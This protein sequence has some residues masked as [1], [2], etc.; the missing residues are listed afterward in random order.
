[1]TAVTIKLFLPFGEANRLRIAEVSNW[2]GMALA[3]PRTDLQ[4]LLERAE[5]DR[6]GIYMLAGVD[7][8]TGK[9]QVYV[10]EAECLR[11]RLRQHRGEDFWVQAYV[12]LSKD[13]NLTKGHVRYLEGRLIEEARAANRAAIVNAQSSGARLPESDRE[14]MEAFLG[15]VRQLLPVLGSD[16]L[17]PVLPAGTGTGA[18]G[19]LVHRIKGLTARG[20]RTAE[21][22]VVLAESQAVRAERP[23][24]AARHPFVVELRRKLLAEGALVSDGEYLRFTR[25][26]VFSSPS[27]AAAVLQGGGANGLTAWRTDGG[28]T[29]KALEA[30]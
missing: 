12:F 17:T 26:V 27:A 3:A 30:G 4:G 18:S 2:S 16:A 21:G 24:A 29:L 13:E 7:P 23:S 28:K 9:P 6:P 5:L 8:H 20:V 15:R 14:D 22:F 19:I 11:D 10:G 25:D 1:M